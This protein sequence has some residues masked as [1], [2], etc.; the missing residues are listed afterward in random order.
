MMD[1]DFFAQLDFLFL[2]LQLSAFYEVFCVQ[3]FCNMYAN[4]PKLQELHMPSQL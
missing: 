1:V 2:I 3:I 4:D